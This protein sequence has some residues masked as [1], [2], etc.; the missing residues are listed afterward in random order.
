VIEAFL[1]FYFL[2]L[3]FAFLFL[4]K[5]NELCVSLHCNFLLTWKL[6]QIAEY[7]VHGNAHCMDSLKLDKPHLLT[8]LQGK[9]ALH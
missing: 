8:I 6:L 7:S 3:C 1:L 2:F 5:D 4:V 9:H